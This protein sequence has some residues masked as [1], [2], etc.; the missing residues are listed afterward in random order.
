M[1]P[2]NKQGAPLLVRENAHLYI[3]GKIERGK[4]AVTSRNLEI[5]LTATMYTAVN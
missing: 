3:L 5:Y 4:V 1:K 2:L